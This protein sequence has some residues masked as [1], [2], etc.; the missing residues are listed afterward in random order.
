MRLLAALLVALVTTLSAADPAP[1]IMLK[2]D[3]LGRWSKDPKAT[4][5]AKWQRVVDFVVA[6]GVKANFGLFAESLEGDCP[7]YA[8]WI[9]ERAASGS[10]EFWHHGYYNRFPADPKVEK[11]GEYINRS[12]EE[13]A[14]TLRRSIDLVKAKTG[15]TIRAFGPHGTAIDDATYAALAGIP[16]IQVVWFYGP[17]K[18]VATTTVLIE[19]R[20]ELEKPIF[21]PNPDNL[22][23]GWEKPRLPG[24]PGP[25]GFVGRS[26]L[27]QF[28]GGGSL[29]E[30]TGMPL[31]HRVGVPGDPAREVAVSRLPHLPP[32][33]PASPA[34]PA[35]PAAPAP[36]G[37]PPASPRT[38]ATALRATGS[39]PSATPTARCPGRPG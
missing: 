27:R 9:T 6:E 2:L 17:H 7:V 10:F 19:R 8:Q 5:P 11:Q 26:G 16:E 30:G 35:G 4:A 3:D 28:P 25:S 14:A 37:T 24:D 21:M 18:G 39:T 22:K 33:R 32:R 20:A 34:I 38:A 31:R 29:P 23:Q 13:Q 15:L 1:M 36:P 12:A